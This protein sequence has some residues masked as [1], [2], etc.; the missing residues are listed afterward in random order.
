MGSLR[1]AM[2]KVMGSSAKKIAQSWFF[3]AKSDVLS[4]PKITTYI[5][6]GEEYVLI[7]TKEGK[8]YQLK[9]QAQTVWIFDAKAS[10]S[11]EEAMFLDEESLNS[12]NTIP[13]VAQIGQHKEKQI[14]V[15]SE[16]GILYCLDEHGQ[17]VWQVKTDGP[18][19]GTPTLRFKDRGGVPEVVVGSNDG[20][21]YVISA[22]GE[23]L[24]KIPVAE[25]IETSPVIID[26]LIVFGTQK[27]KV[28]ALDK[29]YEVRWKFQTQDRI[30]ANIVACDLLGS[31]QEILLVGSQD[32]NVYALSLEGEVEWHFAT[33][34]AIISQVAVADVNDDGKKEVLFGSCDNNVYCIDAKGEL[35]WS[36]ETDFW[37]TATPIVKDIDGDGVLEVVAGSYDHKIYVLDSQGSYK[38]DYMPGISGIIDQSGHYSNTINNEVGKNEGKLFCSFETDGNVVGCAVGEHSNIIITNTKQGKIYG[39]HVK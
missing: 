28:L 6:N 7:G 15:G 1:S 10:F 13:L 34:G 33:D 24:E 21:L 16:S 17:L 23:V 20:H 30:T 29:D 35:I 9:G 4:A 31:G 2:K 19:R 38:L 11:E 26:D 18:I 37:I 5:H 27:G 39:M 25:P 12:L 3:D 36:Y 32:N 8:L 22:G 14:L